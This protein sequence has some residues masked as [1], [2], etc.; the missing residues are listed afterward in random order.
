M[1]FKLQL[2]FNK[3]AIFPELIHNPWGASA[4]G[5]IHDVVECRRRYLA[6]SWL[7]YYP[8]LALNMYFLLSKIALTWTASQTLNIRLTI[9]FSPGLYSH[10]LLYTIFKHLSFA[11]MLLMSGMHIRTQT[12]YSFNTVPCNNNDMSSSSFSLRS[13]YKTKFVS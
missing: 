4:R 7:L 9:S 10:Q 8:A 13:K 1:L 6:M 12:E 2:I 5:G 11:E 3:E